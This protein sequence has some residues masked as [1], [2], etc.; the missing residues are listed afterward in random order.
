M[1][2]SSPK[3]YVIGDYNSHFSFEDS[4]YS[5]LLDNWYNGTAVSLRTTPYTKGENYMINSESIKENLPNLLRKASSD[6]VLY[7]ILNIGTTD[8]K[9]I[10]KKHSFFLD[11]DTYVE[12][13]IF[14][15]NLEDIITQIN[16]SFPKK[17]IFVFTPF[18]NKDLYHNQEYIDIVN[19]ISNNSSL[20]NVYVIDFSSILSSDDFNEQNIIIKQTTHYKVFTMLQQLIKKS[21]PELKPISLSQQNLN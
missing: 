17:K 18:F 3:I 6:N 10:I 2:T 16:Y 19:S 12:P 1:T 8:A 20:S 7:F 5:V 9:N 13:T 15:T 21:C 11:S 4:G 14:K